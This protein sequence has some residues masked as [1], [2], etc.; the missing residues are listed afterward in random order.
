VIAALA[1]AQFSWDLA[2][3]Q[4]WRVYTADVRNRLAAADG[5]ISWE[6]ALALGDPNKNEMWRVM[7][8]GWT[9]PSLSIVLQ[10]GSSVRSMIAAPAGSWQPF[11]P[12]NL[13][14]LPR[15]RGVDY[16]PYVR[17]M[18]EVKPFARTE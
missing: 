9:M 16:S 8:S 6:R 10:S 18:R 2:A 13:S 12:S 3:T 14:N 7:G 17:A 5:L 15:I 4:Q 11:D 1:G